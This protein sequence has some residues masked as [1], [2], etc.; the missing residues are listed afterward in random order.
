[1]TVFI[2]VFIRERE[3]DFETGPPP[4]VLAAKVIVY[5]EYDEEYHYSCITSKAL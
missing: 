4:V 3:R 1:M 2:P 5:S